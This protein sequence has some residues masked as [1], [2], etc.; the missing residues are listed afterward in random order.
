MKH[1]KFLILVLSLFLLSNISCTSEKTTHKNRK[2]QQTL[3]INLLS[4][5]SSLHPH[6]GVDLNCRSFCKALYE[7]LTRTAPDGSVQLAAAKEVWIST[8]QKTYTFTLRTSQWSNGESVTA[9]D[10]E[11]SWKSGIT[12]NSPC[13]RAD[14]FYPIKNA[15]GAKKGVAHL[16]EVGVN[17]LDA[18]TLV[19]ELE[20]PCPYFLDL[21]ANPIYFP[22]YQNEDK[23]TVFNG[24]F[25]LT[26][27]QPDK[28]LRFSRNPSYWDRE[29]VRLNKIVCSVVKDLNTSFLMYEKQESDWTGSFISPI[30]HDVLP[31]LKEEDRLA[32][33][34]VSGIYWYALNTE[35][36]PLNCSK[37]RKALAYAINREE[38]T[39]NVFFGETPSRS[40]VP[41]NISLLSEDELFPDGDIEK[42]RELFAEG[43]QELN[44]TKSEFPKLK[45]SHSD[46]P[47]EKKLAEIIAQQWVK[48]LDIQ[49]EFTSAEWNVYLSNL[50]RGHQYQIGGLI[51][52]YLY[53]DPIY[54]LEFFN[55]LSNLYNA[56]QWKNP[57]F[58][59]LLDLANK[60]TDLETR[61]EH[62]KQ[63]ELLLL[64]EM[65]VIP[66]Y[67]A[68]HKY[69][70]DSPVKDLYF[71]EL[72]MVDFKWAYL[73]E[74]Q[75]IR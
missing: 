19:V 58:L 62:L 23:P 56:P 67:N 50:L 45:L 5:P 47:S 75:Q 28:Q 53:N 39:E 36:Y 15:K 70:K 18:K 59:E 51:W 69:V 42:A 21:I 6:I 29:N 17:A 43:L 65:P 34:E 4:E 20:H 26:S 14:L 61:R 24:P 31:I 9:Y 66:I 13:M 32:T 46:A 40:I 48:A 41:N 3:K 57:H 73:E 63:A 30:S 71:S 35:V 7:G 44:I 72:G 11:A 74:P 10:F 68:H 25:L 37:I 33:K 22:I 27:W 16:E 55:D 49:V 64:D 54:A 2:E 12:P 38:I 52:F 60:E 8:D 1:T